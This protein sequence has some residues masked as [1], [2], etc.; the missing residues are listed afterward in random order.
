M[1]LA[2][3]GSNHD[4]ADG[5][6]RVAERIVL[7]GVSREPVPAA[8]PTIEPSRRGFGSITVAV[9]TVLG[10]AGEMRVRDIHRAIEGLLG[11][12]VSV[13]SVK[14]CL[15][16]KSVGQAPQFE[17]IGRGRYRLVAQ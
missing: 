9:A 5:L 1:G 10:S 11:E 15:A 6:G 14:N 8:A 16:R 2:G 17:R 3:H 7:L 4:L 13:S 12:P